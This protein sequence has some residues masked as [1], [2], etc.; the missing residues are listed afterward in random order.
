MK[1]MLITRR[2]PKFVIDQ[3]KKIKGLVIHYNETDKILTKPELRKASKDAEIII[4]LLTDKIDEE[5]IEGCEKLK[6]IANY[7]VGFDNIDTE[8]A[9][10]KGVL[11]TNTPN[12][13]TQAVAEHTIALMLA[14]A[15]RIV[16]G[17][18][19]VREGKYKYWM[20]DLLIGPEVAGKTL[21]IVGAGR[22]GLALAE[23]AY[24]GFGM[25]II[26]NDM[27]RCEEIER[28]LQGEY[29]SLN[30][31]LEQADFV[32]LNVPLLP[33]TKH[34]IGRKQFNLMKKSA[35]IIN[36]ARGPVIDEVALADALEKK[37]I[38][39]AGID[40][41]EFEPKPVKQLLR[42]DNIILTPHIA[43]A[44][45]EARRGMAECVVANVKEYVTK[46][47]VLNN[48]CK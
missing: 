28:N 16:E 22:I 12:I 31:L 10:S 13:M 7:A 27:N 38:F 45:E 24:H 1:K 25:K 47:N 35:I 11:V 46:A 39:A 3:L 2:L 37:K 18:A 8:F 20:P 23:M 32:S 4:C 19:Y 9:K 41:F 14:C 33:E 21:G 29:Y 5:I 26:Y 48:V 42:L 40:V 36:T 43:S 6:L 15:R 30:H 44:T 17:D 34:M